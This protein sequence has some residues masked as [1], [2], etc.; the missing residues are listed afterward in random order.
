MS[1]VACAVDGTT[2][3]HGVDLTVEPG[4]HVALLGANGS[5]KSSLVRAILGLLPLSSGEI[6]V[7]GHIQP[8]PCPAA[9]ARQLAWI[10]QRPPRGEIPF[11]VGQLVD[12]CRPWGARLGLAPLARRSL[13]SLSGGEL[14][15]VYIARAL[16]HLEERAGILLADE[17]T[18][19]LDFA[20]QEE[21]GELFAGLPATILWITHDPAQAR[22]CHRTLVMA[23]GKLRPL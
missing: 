5:G 14:Q 8:N 11:Q 20:G 13:N 23:Q 21:V 18:S 17:P 3:L 10:P 7:D 9:W 6:A 2:V 19:A 16:E 12:V 1:H 4:E 22:R 15:R